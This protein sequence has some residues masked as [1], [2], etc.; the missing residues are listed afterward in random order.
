MTLPSKVLWSEGL[1]LQPQHLQAHDRHLED[2]LLATSRAIHPFP[3][4]IRQVVPAQVNGHI[5]SLSLLRIDVVLPTGEHLDTPL[6][7]RLPAPLSLHDI[8][9]TCQSFIASVALP[10]ARLDANNVALNDESG[11]RYVNEAFDVADIFGD[12]ATASVHFAVYT[13]R[14]IIDDKATP[15]VS[16]V[17][18]LRLHRGTAGKF[19]IDPTF[20]PPSLTIGSSV[21]LFQRLV[22]LLEN[23]RTKAAALM[24]ENAEPIHQAVAF[25]AGD[26][27]SFWLL[28]TVS[29]AAASLQH[30]EKVPDAS[31]ERLHHELLRLAGGLMAF[32]RA[33]RIADLPAYEHHAPHDGFHLLFK[34]IDKLVDTVIPT[35][36]IPIP[37]EKAGKSY[38]TGTIDAAKIDASASIYLGV[39]A[40]TSGQD[41]ATSVSSRFKIGASDDVEKAVTSAL[42]CVKL[43]HIPIPPPTIPVKPGYA[44][45]LLEAHGGAY[46]RMLKTGAVRV[47]APAGLE[48]LPLE[49]F[50]VVA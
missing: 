17:P 23:L 4:G 25:R 21:P 12:A 43:I 36:F 34:M 39:S 46:E 6:T 3:W 26:H 29:S 2:R 5:E 42:P 13:P 7:S 20:I 47:F 11:R 1:F 10:V 16:K 27:A 45:F 38:F 30:L 48:D 31:P 44:Y 18:V 19:E 32:S 50:A 49:M 37:L 41:L 35:R 22:A 28:H 9:S 8:P 40:G 24:A 33:Y 15:D 14:L